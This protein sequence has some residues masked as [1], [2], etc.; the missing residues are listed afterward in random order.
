MEISSEKLKWA[1]DNKENYI[2]PT[3]LD[4]L[5]TGTKFEVWSEGYYDDSIED[6]CGWYVYTIGE[7]NFRD[8]EQLK[9]EM[10]HGNIRIPK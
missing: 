1:G 7:N 6:F 4:Q 5:P 10:K 8:D 9:T 3:S 2:I